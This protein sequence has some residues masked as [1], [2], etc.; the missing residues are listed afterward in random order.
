MPRNSFGPEISFEYSVSSCPRCHRDNRVRDRV[1]F[2]GHPT[3]ARPANDAPR[4]RLKS[5]I[6]ATPSARSVEANIYRTETIF[7]QRKFGSRAHRHATA[8]DHRIRREPLARGRPAEEGSPVALIPGRDLPLVGVE[9]GGNR[10]GREER[11]GA[12]GSALPLGS[13]TPRGSRNRPPGRGEVEECVLSEL[14]QA[15]M[16]LRTATSVGLP[17]NRVHHLMEDRP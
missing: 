9:V 10:L 3:P 2:L 15:A 13:S 6:N 17:R 5:S 12:A 1:A 8:A 4:L 11:A 14:E 16:E 7:S